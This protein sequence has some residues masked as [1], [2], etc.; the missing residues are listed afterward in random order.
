MSKQNHN[1]MPREIKKYTGILSTSE[2]VSE[3]QSWERQAVM[4]HLEG[5]RAVDIAEAVNKN[6]GTVRRCLQK[7]ATRKLIEDYYEFLDAEYESLYKLALD[8]MR[9]AMHPDSPLTTRVE[10]A[11]HFFKT[12]S[13]S[14]S[15]NGT[16]SAE[17]MIAR[18]INIVQQNGPQQ[19]NYNE[20][21]LSGSPDSDQE[22]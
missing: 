9:D 1:K 15:D 17:S 12:S 11:K 18:V 7:D 4:L 10:T 3:L 21:R 22:D 5:W 6:P 19:H 13:R 2:Q 16:Q 8:S 20:S 14:K